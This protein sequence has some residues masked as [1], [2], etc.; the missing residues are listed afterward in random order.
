MNSSILDIL[1][2]ILFFVLTTGIG[3]VGFFVRSLI[4]EFRD[5]KAVQ[6]ESSKTIAILS[7]RVERHLKDLERIEMRFHTLEREVTRMLS[8]VES[9]SDRTTTLENRID[10]IADRVTQLEQ[11][12]S[13]M[14]GRA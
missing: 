10:T 6:S 14:E 12:T 5:Y 3:V 1:Q 4:Q 7:D 8:G 11:R 9:H 13:R 2:P